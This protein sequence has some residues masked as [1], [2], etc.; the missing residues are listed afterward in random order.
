MKY[1]DITPEISSQTAV[2]PGDVPFSREVHLDFEKDDHL[3]LSSI[4]STLHIGAHA[5]A[6]NHYHPKGCDIASRSLHYYMGD[7][8]VIKL[9]VAPGGRIMPHHLETISIEAPRIL[10][11]TDSFPSPESWES[12]FQSLST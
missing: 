1:I 3:T 5:D 7:C 6:P 12:S 4:R 8:Q 9:S 2:F 11:R 10:F